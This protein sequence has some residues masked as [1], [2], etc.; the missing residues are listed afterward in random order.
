MMLSD[1]VRTDWDTMQTDEPGVFA[2]GDGA[3]G[4]S[5]IVMAM[6]HGQRTA[7]FVKAYLE[8]R[9]DPMPYRTPYRTRRV[10][11]AQ[12]LKWELFGVQEAE[13]HGLGDK[14]I[15]FPE[16]EST[17][18]HQAAKDEAARCYRCDAE[19]GS[20]DYAV[21]HREDIFAMARTNPIDFNRHQ[22]MLDK[23]LVT[24]NNPFP[25]GRPGTL[26]DLVFLPANLSRLVIDPYREACRVSTRVGA[27]VVLDTPFI[28]TGFDDA[29]AE[30][31]DGVA[32]GMA[33]LGTCYMGTKP[34]G[35]GPGWLQLLE[36]DGSADAAAIGLVQPFLNNETPG[37]ISRARSNQIVGFSV[38]SVDLLEAAIGT[39]LEHGH[40]F[41]VLDG[42]GDLGRHG[43]E[44]ASPPDLRIIRNAIRILR[45]LNREEEVDLIYYGG[46]RS[47]TDAAKIIA[48]GTIAVVLGATAGFAVGGEI[49]ADG[50]MHFVANRSTDERKEGII[51][52]LKASVGEASMMAR[53]TG[54][55]NLLNVEPE[56]MRALTLATAK[57]TDI[58]LAGT[59]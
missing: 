7:Y 40:D 51:N 52:I 20:A 41:L 1:R 14:P 57:A 30:V 36:N 28:V 2:A 43:S 49:G 3:F 16:I 26:D 32:E 37:D 19:T 5:T 44:L 4:G 24:R 47:G 39:A 33:E 13:F 35:D 42:T 27:N 56:D 38:S 48:L 17:Y 11:V 9:K 12:D 21:R 46:I 50:S 8:G 22:D 54:K 15:E 25:D 34:I 31:C 59:A 53:C 10:A 23:R 55:T 18:E 58:P 45:G 6:H 29:P